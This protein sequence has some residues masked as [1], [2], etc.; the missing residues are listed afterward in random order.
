MSP[1]K[2]LDQLNAFERFLALAADAPSHQS[3]A[4][5]SSVNVAAT[6]EETVENSVAPVHA[7]AP[8]TPTQQAED[9]IASGISNLNV[10]DEGGVV[11]KKSGRG[12][13]SIDVAKANAIKGYSPSKEIYTPPFV[14]NGG[15]SSCDDPFRQETIK[16]E[17]KKLP[18]SDRSTPKRESI[19]KEKNWRSGSSTTGKSEGSA[20][21]SPVKPK[22]YR[23]IVRTTSKDSQKST[24]PVQPS[25][26]TQT[27]G[28]HNEDVD[29]DSLIRSPPSCCVFVANLLST[30]SDAALKVEVIKVFRQFGVVNV[31]IRRDTRHMPFAF[32]QYDN[33]DSAI[34]AT[35][36]GMG[37]YIA[38]RP[39]RTEKAKAHRLYYFERHAG[40]LSIEE[41]KRILSQFG[42]IEF[43][44]AASPI[45]RTTFNLA[46]GGVMVQFVFYDD[47]KNALNYYHEHPE[48]YRMVDVNHLSKRMVNKSSPTKHRDP[49]ADDAY[50]QQYDVDVRS[51]FVNNLPSTISEQELRRFFGTFGQ[52]IRLSMHQSNSK[53]SSE[54]Y[55][56]AFIEYETPQVAKMVI[57]AMNLREIGGKIIKVKQQDSDRKNRNFHPQRLQ[58]AIESPPV[59]SSQSTQHSQLIQSVGQT[60]LAVA[61]QQNM[62]VQQTIS[63]QTYFNPQQAEMNQRGWEQYHLMQQNYPT[64]HPAANAPQG[65]YNGQIYPVPQNWSAQQG[66]PTQAVYASPQIVSTPQSQTNDQHYC[67]TSRLQQPHTPASPT[68]QAPATS[69]AGECPPYAEYQGPLTQGYLPP[70]YP[71]PPVWALT[72]T[73]QGPMLYWMGAPGPQPMGTT[74]TS[75]EITSQAVLTGQSSPGTAPPPSSQ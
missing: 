74:T 52:I 4:A 38:G 25:T 45:D 53:Y 29:Y 44:Y 39:C 40:S 5:M 51:V 56:F 59:V 24:S 14:R 48:E 16:T 41:A 26:R 8:H 32:V 54:K 57:E 10:S 49:V 36:E 11:V 12:A 20:A 28:S 72:H 2:P 46:E 66:Y 64:Y 60:Q 34:R 69:G 43:A 22:K 15:S 13:Y 18:G 7:P 68:P 55:V 35:S 33:S 31:K 3:S 1:S 70:F 71:P 6:P 61:E 67:S 9:A 63:G 65:A 37:M 21:G 47:G 19:M 58:A 27:L 23:L 30:L 50:L 73:Q 17:N 75:T 42:P 62:P